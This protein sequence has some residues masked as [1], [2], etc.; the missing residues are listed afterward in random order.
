MEEFAPLTESIK[1]AIQKYTGQEGNYPDMHPE[2]QIKY[3]NSRIKQKGNAE[4]LVHDRKR[5]RHTGSPEGKKGTGG[6]KP[7]GLVFTEI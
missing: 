2:M 1:K 6:G 3:R 4:Q 7:A 5:S